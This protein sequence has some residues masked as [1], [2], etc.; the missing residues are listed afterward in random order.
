MIK[1][2]YTSQRESLIDNNYLRQ[3]VFRMN[4]APGKGSIAEAALPTVSLQGGAILAPLKL[5]EWM[6]IRGKHA[7]AEIMAISDIPIPN[8]GL[9]TYYIESS[10]A[11]NVNDML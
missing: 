4:L 7:L 6:H 2:Q 8:S 1:Q 11:T 5:V 10:Q 3:E 9:C